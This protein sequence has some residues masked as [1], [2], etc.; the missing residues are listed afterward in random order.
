MTHSFD[1]D[2]KSTIKS[3]QATGASNLL[4][5]HL[6][7]KLAEYPWQFLVLQLTHTIHAAGNYIFQILSYLLPLLN[8]QSLTQQSLS[9]RQETGLKLQQAH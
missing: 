1:E 2:F 9:M 6:Q 3:C 7:S 5:Y 4:N 8:Q